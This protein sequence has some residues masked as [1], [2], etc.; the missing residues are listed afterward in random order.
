MTRLTVTTISRRLAPSAVLGLALLLQ[1]CSCA[2]LGKNCVTQVE[3]NGVYLVYYYDLNVEPQITTIEANL[4]GYLSV[5]DC[6]GITG[7]EKLHV[8]NDIKIGISDWDDPARVNEPLTYQFYVSNLG[9][10]KATGI[11]VEVT[12]PA[13]LNLLDA[14]SLTCAP[15]N[16]D[17]VCK[18]SVAFDLA[19]DFASFELRVMPTAA[20]L[21]QVS[22]TAKAF[23]IEVDSNPNNNVAIER[24]MVKGSEGPNV[25]IAAAPNPVRTGS[26]L[27]FTIDVQNNEPVP[28]T[29]VVLE[30]FFF[31]D[32]LE[33]RD[34]STTVSSC[35]VDRN[36]SLRC[37]LG[38]LANGTNARVTIK[39]FPLQSGTFTKS[40]RVTG[41][42]NDEYFENYASVTFT[43][44]P[45]D[46]DVAVSIAAA[47]NPVTVNNE[48]TFTILLRN[49]NS[50][51]A[52]TGVTMT[53]FNLLTVGQVLSI[54][55]TQGSCPRAPGGLTCNIGTLAGSASAT[56]TIR[57][58]PS[59]AG[60]FNE[61][62]GV[63]SN[64]DDNA[65]NNSA[66][67]EVKVNPP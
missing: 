60:L 67:V 9:T 32:Y 16:G 31:F 27:T 50:Q 37:D 48:L 11:N 38:E 21:G 19:N 20:A 24:T 55:T 18:N 66:S 1:G 28:A 43:V 4:G 36:S 34:I 39:A 26:E 45:P 5:C 30:G 58:I 53:G 33:G 3:E 54:Q 22:I 29:N 2:K 62:V 15:A 59:S 10:E 8:A 61:T 14:G 51:V 65:A 44:N 64:Y 6:S 17:L 40:V 42:N 13:T 7:V 25:S 57:S 46:A 49:L 56:V 12:L 41:V 35:S 52:A 23:A 63:T 47:P